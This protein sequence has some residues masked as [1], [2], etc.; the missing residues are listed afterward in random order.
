MQTRGPTSR[1]R[2]SPA[3]ITKGASGRVCPDALETE[4]HA[5]RVRHLNK[6][7]WTNDQ[8]KSLFLQTSTQP[9]RSVPDAPGPEG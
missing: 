6:V 5:A 3:G 8:V 9:P 1:H 2:A 4:A 7:K